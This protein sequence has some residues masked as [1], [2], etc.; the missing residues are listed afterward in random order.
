VSCAEACCAQ[1]TCEESGFLDGGDANEY[2]TARQVLFIFYQCVVVLMALAISLGFLV[3]GTR[4]VLV[5]YRT[6]AVNSKFS[7]LRRSKTI[8]VRL[9]CAVVRVRVRVRVCVCVS[10]VG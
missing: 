4:L 6:E 3:Y 7:K 8:K 1:N 5:L 2:Q 10:C 9:A